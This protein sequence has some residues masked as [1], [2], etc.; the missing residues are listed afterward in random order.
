ML[1]PTQRVFTVPPHN[2][3]VPFITTS[4]VVAPRAGIE[5]AWPCFRD[6]IGCQQ[7][8]SEWLIFFFVNLTQEIAIRASLLA[9]TRLNI[10]S[11]HYTHLL[12]LS[13]D[14]NVTVP[15]AVFAAF[16][17]TFR[18]VF[19]VCGFLGKIDERHGTPNCEDINYAT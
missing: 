19:P 3:V 1:L 11:T 16:T 8:I 6:T 13:Q 4:E 12:N 10:H 14:Q 5:P 2:Q 9:R 17:T 18:T 15:F 7:P